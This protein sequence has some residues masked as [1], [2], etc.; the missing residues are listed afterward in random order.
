[1][2]KFFLTTAAALAFATQVY[3]SESVDIQNQC[4]HSAQA[5]IDM[6]TDEIQA[7]FNEADKKIDALSP[8]EQKRVRKELGIVRNEPVRFR[9]VGD[10]IAVKHED[11]IT[12]CAMRLD[13]DN[14]RIQNVKLHTQQKSLP[15]VFA[16]RPNPDGSGP[17]VGIIDQTK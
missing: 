15:F 6:I 16:V 5:A 13:S 8:V 10:A 14:Q 2:T 9:L 4:S 17:Q 3:A 11:N 12:F 7:S 1:M